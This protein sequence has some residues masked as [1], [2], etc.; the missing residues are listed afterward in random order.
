MPDTWPLKANHRQWHFLALWRLKWAASV[1]LN[2]CALL[3]ELK[4]HAEHYN[5]GPAQMRSRGHL[6]L[7]MYYPVFI[8]IM[9]EFCPL[10]VFILFI[11]SSISFSLSPFFFFFLVLEIRNI[12]P[13]ARRSLCA[14][15]PGPVKLWKNFCCCSKYLREWCFQARSHL[16]LSEDLLCSCW[17]RLSFSSY[18]W[19]YGKFSLRQFVW[20]GSDQTALQAPFILK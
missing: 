11:L 7:T 13:A 20:R 10:S 4:P 3:L 5:A 17:T 6:E 18:R 1:L 14:N 2:K 8:Y 15:G 19:L 9:S 16:S 12:N